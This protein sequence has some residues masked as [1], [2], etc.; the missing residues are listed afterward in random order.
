MDTG[1]W[2]L[3]ELQITST[4]TLSESHTLSGRAAQTLKILLEDLDLKPGRRAGEPWR[5]MT[6]RP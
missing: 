2:P 4:A 3:R 5:P 1:F 6:Y